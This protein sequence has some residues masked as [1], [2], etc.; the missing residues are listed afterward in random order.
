MKI[1]A[2][3]RIENA[4]LGNRFPTFRAPACEWEGHARGKP[5]AGH[6]RVKPPEKAGLHRRGFRAAP[7]KPRGIGANGPRGI[8]AGKPRGISPHGERAGPYELFSVRRRVR[9]GQEYVL[10]SRARGGPAPPSH[11]HTAVIFP[12]DIFSRGYVPG[13]AVRTASPM[14]M[15]GRGEHT[16]PK[17]G[18]RSR[19]SSVGWPS[20]P[21]IFVLCRRRLLTT[22]T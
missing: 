3:R 17:A 10:G 8:G 13:T 12:S 20:R 16:L 11:G 19:A 22:G 9:S 15:R 14:L 6:C 1:P 18:Q 5:R 4:R 2:A 21:V 7:K